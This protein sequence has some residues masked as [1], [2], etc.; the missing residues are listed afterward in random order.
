MKNVKSNYGNTLLKTQVDKHE[1]A[2]VKR[3]MGAAK[4]AQVVK[5]LASMR[6]RKNYDQIVR[7]LAVEMSK[8]LAEYAE[9]IRI[10]KAVK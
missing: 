1:H 9:I 3:T 10:G 6:G 8:N 4:K 7:G 2:K 5:I